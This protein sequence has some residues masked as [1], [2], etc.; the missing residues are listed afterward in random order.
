MA[1]ENSIFY[2]NFRRLPSGFRIID[3]VPGNIG[4]QPGLDVRDTACT[5][6]ACFGFSQPGGWQT[7]V[8]IAASNPTQS[9]A[10]GTTL[11]FGSS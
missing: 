8:C 1:K 7:G 2:R 5:G 3:Y 6:S 4:L 10:V 11:A 9:S